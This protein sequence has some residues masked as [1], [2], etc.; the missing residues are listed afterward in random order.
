MRRLTGLLD[1]RRPGAIDPSF[2]V[3]TPGLLVFEGTM[4]GI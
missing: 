1:R 3:Q 4:Y 2:M